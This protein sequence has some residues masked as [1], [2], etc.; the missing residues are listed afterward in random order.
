MGD[1][2]PASTKSQWLGLCAYLDV[3]YS[4]S[5]ERRVVMFCRVALADCLVHMRWMY[6]SI[7]VLGEAILRNGGGAVIMVMASRS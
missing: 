5:S 6:V 4:V 1:E 3:A 7:E 2:R